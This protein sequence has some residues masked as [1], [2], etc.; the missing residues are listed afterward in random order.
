V[1]GTV[2]RDERRQ[3][4]GKVRKKAECHNCEGEIRDDVIGAEGEDDES[5]EEQEYGYEK[6]ERQYIDKPR[7]PEPACTS[8]KVFPNMGTDVGCVVPLN[9]LEI[10]AGPLLQECSHERACETEYEAEEPDRVYKY[11][12]CR[13][14][15]GSLDGWTSGTT[16]GGIR[17]LLGYLCEEGLGGDV[18]ILLQILVADSDKTSHC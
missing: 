3:C 9:H 14:S 16:G 17:K 7:D 6:K 11:H 12:R 4:E 18:G 8:C 13:R 15:E 2:V 10:P 5:G 1:I